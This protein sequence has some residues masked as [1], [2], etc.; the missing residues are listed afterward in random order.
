MLTDATLDLLDVRLASARTDPDVAAAAEALLQHLG[1]SLDELTALL[2]QG[3]AAHRELAWQLP[4]GWFRGTP[5]DGMQ[6]Y[7]TEDGTT[8]VVDRKSTRLNSSHR[9]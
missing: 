8:E 7:V 6:R 1:I 9:R 3:L 2:R 4:P 5:R